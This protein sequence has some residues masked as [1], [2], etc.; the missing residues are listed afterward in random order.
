MDGYQPSAVYD[1]I[2]KG[3]DKQ[4]KRSP[5]FKQN[6]KTARESYI[7]TG[8]CSCPVCGREIVRDV[9]DL[10]LCGFDISLGRRENRLI[11]IIG[12]IFAGILMCP[13]FLLKLWVESE[14]DIYLPMTVY[15]I[16]YIIFGIVVFFLFI[17]IMILVL[18]GY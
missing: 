11:K 13:L 7:N 4:M 15:I 10:C 1:S 8:I 3:T 16:L 9:G 2:K 12:S 6:L 5:E 18:L 14:F 17:G